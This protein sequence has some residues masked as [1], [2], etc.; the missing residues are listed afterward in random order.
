[1]LCNWQ[2][3]E[4]HFLE[5]WGDIRAFDGTAT[6]QQPLIAP[7]VLGG[8]PPSRSCR[9]C[10][11]SR[12]GRRS[13][14]S[15]TPGGLSTAR[16]GSRPSGGPRCTTGVV[17]GTAAEPKTVALKG[18]IDWCELQA[19]GSPPPASWSSSSGPTRPIWDGC[20]RQQR[21]A[22]GAAQAA[23]EADLGQRRPDE[24]MRPRPGCSVGNEQI[25][26]LTFRARMLEVPVW[27]V[28]GHAD[29]SVTLHLGYGRRRVGRVGDGV[30][31][32]AYALRTSESPWFGTGL[33]A[34]AVGRTL[35][36]GHD[37][38]PLRHGR[39]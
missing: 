20:Y 2:V 19:R 29:D 30:G 22:P 32:D 14:S 24:P 27:V 35:S 16:T 33:D 11:V 23:D 7:A 3:P 37:P 10:S 5:T 1:M 39:P 18:S 4:A 38:A 31:F 17:E 15:P 12:T 8:R 13:S 36:T 28:P 9:P 26:E 6:I 34:K 25:V 21:L